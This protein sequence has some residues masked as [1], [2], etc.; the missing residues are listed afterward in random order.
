MRFSYSFYSMTYAN[1]II[2]SQISSYKNTHE[3]EWGLT[4]VLDSGG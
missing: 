1:S 2:I 4:F 3:E